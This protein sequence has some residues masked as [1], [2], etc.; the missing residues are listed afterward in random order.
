MITGK[1]RGHSNET[2]HNKIIK[3]ARIDS[4][5][6]VMV[7]TGK[8]Y[9]TCLKLICVFIMYNRIIF[10]KINEFTTYNEFVCFTNFIS[11]LI[12]WSYTNFFALHFKIQNEK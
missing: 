8:L 12:I 4:V 10:K 2:V 11:V 5:G 6:C 1:R 3:T 7:K 9:I